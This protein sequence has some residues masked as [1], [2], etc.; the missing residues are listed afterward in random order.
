MDFPQAIA[1][2]DEH[3]NIEATVDGPKAGVVHGLSLDRMRGIVDVL[4]DPQR[5]APVIHITGTNGKGS[6]ARMIAAAQAGQ[7]VVRLKGGD[8]LL[9]SRLAE[10][11]QALRTAGI[12]YEILPGVTAASAAAARLQGEL[13]GGAAASADASIAKDDAS[14]VTIADFAAQ[15][16]RPARVPA[17]R[18]AFPRGLGKTRRGAS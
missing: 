17:S 14:P 16:R 13:C 7:F 1:Y 12:D 10:E 9:F 11:L 15:A 3:I 4:G 6:T 8:A 5:S 18:R 2:L